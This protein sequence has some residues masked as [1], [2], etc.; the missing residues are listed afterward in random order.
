[1]ID[2]TRKFRVLFLSILLSCQIFTINTFAYREVIANVSAYTLYDVEE[3]YS[4]EI[5][6]GLV[7]TIGRT[8]AMDDVPFGTPV[9][10]NG[11]IYYVEDCFGGDYRNRVDILMSSRGD[12][13]RFGRQ[14]ILIK[15]YDEGENE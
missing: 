8:I 7:P 14:N 4:E 10:I 11:H 6:S 12:A 15:I 3:G 13:F 5:A 9:E 2:I 1:M